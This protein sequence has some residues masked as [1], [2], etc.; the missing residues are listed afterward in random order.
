[1]GDLDKN[2]YP[3]LGRIVRELDNGDP[4]NANPD[5]RA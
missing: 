1:M 5:A 2:H 3:K 4:E